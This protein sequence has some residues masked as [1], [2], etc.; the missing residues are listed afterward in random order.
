MLNFFI[1]SDLLNTWMLILKLSEQINWM[2][3]IL[4]GL[5]YFWYKGKC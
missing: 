5:L 2:L 3:I 4:N 1:D